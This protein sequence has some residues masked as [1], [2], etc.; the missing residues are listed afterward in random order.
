MEA[1]DRFAL[2]EQ[3]ERLKCVA[4][5]EDLNKRLEYLSKK[6]GISQKAIINMA[7]KD[8]IDK[9]AKALVKNPGLVHQMKLTTQI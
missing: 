9:K 5:S 2:Y 4:I 3:R 6:I 8:W 7:V 1:Q